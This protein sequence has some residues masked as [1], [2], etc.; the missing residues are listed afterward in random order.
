MCHW[1]GA[2]ISQ[3]VV[4]QLHSSLSYANPHPTTVCSG[5]DSTCYG[6][7]LLLDVGVQ[8]LTCDNFKHTTFA[9]VSINASVASMLRPR[10]TTLKA[11]KCYQAAIWHTRLAWEAEWSCRASMQVTLLLRST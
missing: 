3:H 8:Y 6:S 1:V 7:M 9:T 10:G 2:F 11:P 5:L 4:T